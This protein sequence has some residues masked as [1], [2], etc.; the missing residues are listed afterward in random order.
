MA[1]PTL[2]S[3]QPTTGPSSGGD[4]VRLVGTDFADRVRVLF[5]GVAAE[6]P[7]VRDEAGLRLV[8]LRTP[9][10]AP[11]VVGVELQNLD[12]AGVPVPGESVV[13]VGAYRFARPTVA[14]EADLTRVVRQ[15][16]RELKRQVLANVSATVSVDYD[17]TTLDGLN[18]IAMA[19]VPS[20]VLSGPTLRPNRFYSANVAHE[21]VVDGIAGPEL[22]RRK[23]PYTVDLV[24]TLTA[25]S[26]RT[27]ELFNLMAVVATFLNRNR[28][29]E[30]QRDPS[31]ASRG[32]VRWELDADGEFRTQ[33]AG[34]DDVRAF[35]CGVVVRG[36][37]VDEGLPLD[38]GKRVT[39]PELLPAQAIATGGTP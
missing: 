9:V 32:V 21:D 36:F 22:A 28:W 27:A 19:K 16:L 26:E 2:S 8:D 13:L 20:L 35:T 31:D 4:L 1:L 7:S 24:F 38:L 25:A 12:A 29:L 30:L 37:D 39:E 17:D 18:L 34:K 11:G 14:R 15:L 3:V 5:G 10:H 23:P 33:L 6:A